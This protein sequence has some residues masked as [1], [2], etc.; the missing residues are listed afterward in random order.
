MALVSCKASG[1]VLT[2]GTGRY[3]LSAGIPNPT[4][5]IRVCAT[6]ICR[7]RGIADQ[8]RLTWRSKEQMLLGHRMCNHSGLMQK[9]PSKGIFPSARWCH[10]CTRHLLFPLACCCYIICRGR[11]VMTAMYWKAIGSCPWKDAKHVDI[12]WKKGFLTSNRG[13][14]TNEW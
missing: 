7:K 6:C 14:S 13:W 5:S 10:S 1:L 4:N 9:N 12:S 3:L 11:K 2:A 8:V